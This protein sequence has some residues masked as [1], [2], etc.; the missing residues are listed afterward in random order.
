[1]E[2]LV[3]RVGVEVRDARCIVDGGEDA[4]AEVTLLGAGEL[5]GREEVLVGGG[6]IFGER[7]AGAAAI[8]LVF[9]GVFLLSFL[10]FWYTQLRR[11]EGEKG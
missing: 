7:G 10:P 6:R 1:V 4:A 3:V 9:L 8:L 2:V 11:G 5:A